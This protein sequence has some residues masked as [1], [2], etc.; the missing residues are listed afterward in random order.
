MVA[1]MH[2]ESNH[3]AWAAVSALI[4]NS[5]CLLHVRSY[6]CVPHSKVK[7]SAQ[8]AVIAFDEVKE[9]WAVFRGCSCTVHLTLKVALLVE[10][11]A[12]GN[13]KIVLT[14]ILHYSLTIGDTLDYNMV[15]CTCSIGGRS[16][17]LR[18]DGAKVA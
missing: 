3:T 18:I 1:A 4:C 15:Q 14:E 9:P 5:P 13:A 12:G 11:K 17:V 2:L 10:D 7:R 6:Q 8:S 16:V